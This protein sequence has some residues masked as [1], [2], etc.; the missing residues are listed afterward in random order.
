MTYLTDRT[1]DDSSLW[2]F[3]VH[4]DAPP[5][6]TGTTAANGCDQPCPHCTSYYTCIV[7]GSHDGTHYCDQGHVWSG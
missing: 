4:G 2:H 5:S 7:P 1:S 3:A 6:D